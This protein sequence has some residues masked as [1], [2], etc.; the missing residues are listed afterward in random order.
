MDDK[1]GMTI[2][3]YSKTVKDYESKTGNLYFHEELNFLKIIQI[4][5]N[6]CIIL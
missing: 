2:S 5:K 4:Y 3:T 6:M 1:T